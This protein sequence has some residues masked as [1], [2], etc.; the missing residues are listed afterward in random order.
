[1]PTTDDIARLVAIMVR[2]HQGQRAAAL[3]RAA[4]GDGNDSFSRVAKVCG[5]S[6]SVVQAWEDG[7]AQPTTQEGLAW[8]THLYAIQ[9]EPLQASMGAYER[10]V[11]GRQFEQAGEQ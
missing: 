5:T 1:M 4:Y 9:P 3:R 6:P 11:R 8:L 2:Q 7:I 10:E